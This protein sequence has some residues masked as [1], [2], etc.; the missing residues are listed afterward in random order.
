M[1]RKLVVLAFSSHTKI[2]EEGSTDD[3]PHAVKKKEKKVE[4]SSL[5][6]HFHSLDQ[7]QSA[8]LS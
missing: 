2:L 8:G 7:D 5:A 6:H 3:S 1:L 4:I